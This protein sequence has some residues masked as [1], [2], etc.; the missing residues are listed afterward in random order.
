MK[1]RALLVGG[2]LTIRN[3]PG[4]PGTEVTLTYTRDGGS[5]QTVTVTLGKA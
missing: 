4:T 3:K 5:P 1:E 2:D